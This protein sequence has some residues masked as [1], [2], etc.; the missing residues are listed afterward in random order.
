MAFCTTVKLLPKHTTDIALHI[1]VTKI[2]IF[3]HISD[4]GIFGN[5]VISAS[6]PTLPSTFSEN[7]L[8]EII[9]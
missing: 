9:A 7:S 1:N 4:S 2:W 3:S 5:S 6:A 8:E